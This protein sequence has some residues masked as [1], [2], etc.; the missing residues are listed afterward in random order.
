MNFGLFNRAVMEKCGDLDEC[1]STEEAAELTAK[2]A[3]KDVSSLP[4]PGEVD[5]INGGPPCQV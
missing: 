3:L 2:L 1:I 4:L 5:F